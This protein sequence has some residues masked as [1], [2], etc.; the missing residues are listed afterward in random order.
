MWCMLTVVNGL[1][2]N[3]SKSAVMVFARESV[4]GAWNLCL[5]CLSTQTWVLT[6]VHEIMSYQEG[7][8]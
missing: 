8:G 7:T 4:D 5:E 3:V 6:L 2:A 1:K